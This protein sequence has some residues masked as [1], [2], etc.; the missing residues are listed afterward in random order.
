MPK[1]NAATASERPSPS[2]SAD[3]DDVRALL[4]AL[5]ESIV[6]VLILV[7]G[8]ALQGRNGLTATPVALFN[9]L[10]LENRP[11]RWR[12][13]YTAV[14]GF[15]AINGVRYTFASAAAI[16]QVLTMYEPVSLEAAVPLL[17]ALAAEGFDCGLANAWDVPGE[18]Q[19]RLRKLPLPAINYPR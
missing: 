11:S 16:E 15:R 3:E 17:A 8:P 19:P 9:W 4:D 7:P 10:Q 18:F 14:N 6:P 13:I 12:L 5:T 1:P 2:R